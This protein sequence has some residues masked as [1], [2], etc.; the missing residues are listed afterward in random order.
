MSRQFHWW[1][2]R[3]EGRAVSV[4]DVASS[5]DFDII[6]AVREF[7]PTTTS[8][9]ALSGLRAAKRK[10]WSGWPRYTAI[11]SMSGFSPISSFRAAWIMSLARTV[12]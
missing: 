5:S 4:L 3:P 8:H 11:L 2:D 1:R 12:L 9:A 6:A 7:D 10:I